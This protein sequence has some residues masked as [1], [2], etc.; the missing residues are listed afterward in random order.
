ALTGQLSIQTI[1]PFAVTGPE[2]QDLTPKGA[3]ARGLLAILAL[4]DER[5]RPR[6][7]LEEKLWSGRGAEQAGQSLRQALTEIRRA[8]GDY[9]DIFEVDRMQVRLAPEAVDVDF[10]GEIA[11]DETRELLEG[12]K[13]RDDAFVDWQAEVRDAF[14][15]RK[16]AKAAKSK[17]LVLRLKPAAEGSGAAGLLSEHMS[18]QIGQNIAE[19]VRA[20]RQVPVKVADDLS[21]AAE[22]EIDTRVIEDQGRSLA[23]IRL[24]HAGT[25]RVLHTAK[26]AVDAATHDVAA[27]DMLADLLV[28]AA[29]RALDAMATAFPSERPEI[30]SASLAR[31]AVREMESFEAARLDVADRLLSSAY[32]IDRNGLFLAWQSLLR[33][34][35]I[36]E[37]VIP[38]DDAEREEIK[39]LTRQALELD[40][41]NPLVQALVNQVTVLREADMEVAHI[42]AQQQ[43]MDN[44]LAGAFG[45]STLASA[46]MWMGNLGRAYDLT[47]RASDIARR[48]TFHHWW[49]T[50]H[51]ISC[52]ASGK[53]DEAIAAGERARSAAPHFRPPLRHLLAL[54]AHKNEHEKVDQIRNRLRILEPDFSMER[55]RTDETYPVRTLRLAGLLDFPSDDG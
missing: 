47:Q 4:T 8:F 45:M 49:D 46:E 26:A 11:S 54:Y 18:H 34:I 32:D 50:F 24:T 12:L 39:A 7:F 1:G 44:S 55:F 5:T 33:T 10:D 37:L 29:E 48:S 23:F 6:R 42:V 52:I 53:F 36:T 28:E 41:D 9:K 27:D 14:E 31:R 19:Q 51:C 43:R 15:R 20:W 38:D 25:G 3:K 35:Q 30:A 2:G 22:I 40:G 21:D 16:S 13:I 17:G